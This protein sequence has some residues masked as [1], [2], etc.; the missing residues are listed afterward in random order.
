MTKDI[1]KVTKETLTSKNASSVPYPK[2][3]GT[4]PI[5]KVADF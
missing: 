1:Y 3:T 2:R 5:H 4:R